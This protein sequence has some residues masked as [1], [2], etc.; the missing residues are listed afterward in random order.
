MQSSCHRWR[1]AVA[2]VIA[3]LNN[4]DPYGLEPGVE[5]GAPEDEYETEAHSI[6]TLLLNSGSVSRSQVDGIWREWF[7]EPLSEVIGVTKVERFC[8][9]LNSLSD[10][11]WCL[12]DR[13]RALG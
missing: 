7:Q 13:L 9:S 10:S 1:S 11:V 6:A 3:L 2:A 5:G 4:L 8:I 12:P